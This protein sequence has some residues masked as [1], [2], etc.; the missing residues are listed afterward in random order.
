MPDPTSA[1]MPCEAT[2]PADIPPVFRFAPSPNGPLHLGHARSA[3][4]CQDMARA[5]GGR[6]LIRIEDVDPARSRKIHEDSI[7]TDLRQLGLVSDGPIRRQSEH[8]AD[9][10]AALES[11]RQRDL[12]YPAFLSRTDTRARVEQFEATGRSWPRD[13]EG[14]P[15]H[16]PDDRQ[17]SRQEADARM[18]AGE[19]FAW[20]LN[21]NAALAAIGDGSESRELCWQESG[22][23]GRL[24]S[25]D[26]A[27]IH[28]RGIGELRW[29]PVTAD[30]AA[31]GDVVLA[32]KDAPASYH[33]AVVIDDA[34]QSVTDIV[35]GEDLYHATAV[36]RLLQR[37]L[38]LP[39]PRYHHHSLIL[40]PD[41]RKL[42]KSAGDAGLSERLAAGAGVDEIRA[43]VGLAASPPEGARTSLN[44]A[45]DA[46]TSSA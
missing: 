22:G 7:L 35:R 45:A 36:H 4:I 32:R 10:L 27:A 31:W 44:P 46:A 19:L 20:R 17:R 28:A 41:G 15:L 6:F 33:L 43:L 11:L 13:P 21:M 9:Y 14:A 39:E 34:L 40:G 2:K 3:L 16:P 29:T 25:A 12:I 5:A 8:A 37:L 23:P 18:A 38:G 1:E 30:P 42:A 26:A 24:D